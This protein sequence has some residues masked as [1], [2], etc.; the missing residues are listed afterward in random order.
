ME[1]VPTLASCSFD[2]HGLILIIFDKPHQRTFKNDMHVSSLLL[3]LFA[4]K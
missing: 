3:T 4:F 2:E 1:N